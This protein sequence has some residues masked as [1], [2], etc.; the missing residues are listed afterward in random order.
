MQKP[1]IIIQ[2]LIVGT[3]YFDSEGTIKGKNMT[4]NDTIELTFTPKSFMQKESLIKG[5]TYDAMGKKRYEISGNW[6]KQIV[7][8]NL[9]TKQT[10]VVFEDPP[11]IPNENR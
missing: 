9:Q 11:P 5:V 3:M 4:T 7:L 8:K 6:L 1:T 10:Q 2:N